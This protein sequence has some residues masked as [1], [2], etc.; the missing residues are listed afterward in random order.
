MMT[1]RIVLT[2]IRAVVFD[3][4]DTLYPERD[5]V[6]SGFDAVGDWLRA[7]FPCSFD[8]ARRMRELFEAGHRGHVFDRLLEEMGVKPDV[9]LIAD[10]VTCYRT[11]QPRI[12]LFEDAQRAL[13][14]WRKRFRVGLISDGPLEMQ[15]NKVQAL[16]LNHLIE[17][18]VLTDQWSPEY[19]KPHPRAFAELEKVFQAKGRECVYLADNAS[20][21]FIAPRQRGW[22][23]VQM[24]RP[25]GIHSHLNAPAGGSPE[26]QARSFDEIELTP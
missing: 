23:T 8:P 11:H 5:F 20:K 2:G 25:G 26:C 6:F 16:G 19:W 4:D 22:R 15:K 9:A 17:Q 14:R 12:R 13:E 1:A 24:Q 21:D 7:R 18:I 10:M 3:L